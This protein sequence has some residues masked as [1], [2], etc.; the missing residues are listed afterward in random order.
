MKKDEE[1]KKENIDTVIPAEKNESHGEVKKKVGGYELVRKVMMCLFGA[2]FLVFMVITVMFMIRNV[3]ANKSNENIME[4]FNQ[5]TNPG[6][7]PDNN[8]PV[9]AD[10]EESTGNT[11]TPEDDAYAAYVAEC[12]AEAK[13]LKSQYPD[14]RAVIIIE[15]DTINLK[16]PVFQTTDNKYYVEHLVDGSKNTAG[17]LFLDYRNKGDILENRNTTI[18]GHNMNNGTKFGQL[19]KYKKNNAFYTHNITI[20]TTEAVLTFKPFSFY[21]TDIYNNYT[22]GVFSN[23]AAFA[24]FCRSEQERSMF[25][26]DIEFTGK[27]T[28]ITLSTCYGTSKTERY[29]LHAVLVNIAK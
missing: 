19:H 15:G 7:L 24:E 3:N 21:K 20:V 22:L 9:V 28:I 26:S 11:Q 1:I 17:E 27:E 29:C 10:P 23:D 5:I 16:Y 25:K 6:T 8:D 18:Y 13:K 14:F 4:D 2:M 12:I